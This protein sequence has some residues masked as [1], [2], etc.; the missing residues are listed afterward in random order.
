MELP[1]SPNSFHSAEENFS[2]E[3]FENVFNR[4]PSALRRIEKKVDYYFRNS[5]D[6]IYFDSELAIAAFPGCLRFGRVEIDY[7]S[8][9][10]ECGF[11]KSSVLEVPIFL[12]KAFVQEIVNHFT[13]FFKQSIKQSREANLGQINQ[14]ISFITAA[15]YQNSEKYCSFISK[16]SENQVIYELSFFSPQK[17]YSF[18][19]CIYKVVLSVTSPTIFQQDCVALFLHKLS[20]KSE[21]M[22]NKLFEYWGKGLKRQILW[23]GISDTLEELKHNQ[24]PPKKTFLLNFIMNNI[25]IIYSMFMLLKIIENNQ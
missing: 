3:S 25:D 20:V 12:T 15:I 1:N 11:T 22:C 23:N 6:Y 9:I 14:G 17:L 10:P 8:H 2:D 4:H 19:Q 7:T 24:E 5:L 18:A 13:F 21:N 16:S